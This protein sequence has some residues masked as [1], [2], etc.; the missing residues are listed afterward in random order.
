LS[1]TPLHKNLLHQK[2]TLTSSSVVHKKGYLGTDWKEGDDG[3][4]K[5]CY[6]RWEK[7]KIL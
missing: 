2:H 3:A 6:P 7:R 5:F 1:S 4:S